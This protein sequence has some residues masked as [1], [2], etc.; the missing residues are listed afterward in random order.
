[1]EW[2]QGNKR[3]SAIAVFHSLAPLSLPNKKAAGSRP[4]RAPARAP[5]VGCLRGRAEH[6]LRRAHQ[7]DFSRALP[8]MSWGGPSEGRFE[9]RDLRRRAQGRQW[10]RGAHRRPCEYE[11]SVRRDYRRGRSRTHAAE[12][13]AAGF[14]AACASPLAANRSSPHA[15]PPSSRPA[16]SRPAARCP[17]PRNSPTSRRLTRI[18]H[19]PSS[20]WRRAR[21][22]RCSRSQGTNTCG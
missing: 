15:T 2:R 10:R 6:H 8:Q 4:V 13:A 14:R 16:R 11:H 20:R 12:K 9:S 5:R 19:S 1:M 22:P 7:A 18:A 3:H 17:C 21:A